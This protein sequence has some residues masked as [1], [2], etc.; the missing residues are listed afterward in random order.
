M[1][2]EH[3]SSASEEKN[4]RVGCTFFKEG[5]YFNKRVPMHIQHSLQKAFTNS[6][7]GTIGFTNLVGILIF[8]AEQMTVD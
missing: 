1:L 6:P 8:A 2:G 4:G 5:E 3:L 7:L